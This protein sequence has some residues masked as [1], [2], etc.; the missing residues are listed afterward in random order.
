MVEFYGLGIDLS[1]A[2]DTVVRA[3]A[4]QLFQEAPQ[5][6]QRMTQALLSNTSLCVRVGNYITEA[7]A[8]N[9][10]SPQ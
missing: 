7:F 6:V 8:T 5:D 1:K 4:Q 3:K 9:T 10:G 2:F